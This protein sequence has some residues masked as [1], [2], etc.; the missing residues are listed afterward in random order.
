MAACSTDVV[1][2]AAK[3]TGDLTRPLAVREPA[4]A[5][6][7]RL[8]GSGAALST[9][10]TRSPYVQ[11]VTESSAIV[12]FSAPFDPTLS[13]EIT[14]PD[15][16]LVSSAA[17]AVDTPAGPD[18]RA[19]LTAFLTDLSPGTTYCYAI[20]S[21]TQRAGFATPPR[22]GTDAPVRFVAWGD[23]GES[24]EWQSVVFEQM[25]TVPFELGLHL[26]DVA[27]ESGTPDELEAEYFDVYASVLK[28]LPVYAIAGN[29]DYATHGGQPL[30]QA[31]VLPTNGNQER[32]Y[33]FDRGPVH[34]VGLDTE[35]IGPDQ[36]AWLEQDLQNNRLPWSIVFGHRPPFS[37][38]EHGDNAAFKRFFVPILERYHVD[39]VLSGHDHDYE[40]FKPINGV[41]YVVSGGG[42]RGTRA[43]GSSP[44]TAF[45]EAVLDFVYVEV[46]GSSL[47][48]HAIDGVGREFDQAVVQH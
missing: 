42:G 40:R 2:V 4:A 39:L 33:S 23:S 21:L 10:L 29:H 24:G 36:A 3:N 41:Q 11:Q 8:C 27:Y 44:R 38:G 1:E 34:F 9:A 22:V 15:G 31:F 48:L 7:E 28:N 25:K 37:S 5:E 45:S 30:R 12:A 47:T 17:V 19:T 18:G 16:V 46:E 6:L 26:G 20:P 14:T 13:V 35:Q 32:W 43:M